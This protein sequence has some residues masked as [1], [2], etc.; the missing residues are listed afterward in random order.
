VLCLRYAEET[1]AKEAA[2]HEA[3]QQSAEKVEALAA[4]A[5]AQ[6]AKEDALGRL[7]AADGARKAAV[8]RVAVLQE[9]NNA[10]LA[11]VRTSGFLHRTSPR[12]DAA[13]AVNACGCLPHRGARMC[14][15]CAWASIDARQHSNSIAV[16]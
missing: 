10:L 2:L 15:A 7:A 14:C 11:V 8:R 9:H 12:H 13:A 1:A 5:A 3:A 16:L 6:A 4:A